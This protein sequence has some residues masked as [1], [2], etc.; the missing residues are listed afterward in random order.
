MKTLKKKD[1]GKQ[2]YK[3]VFDAVADHMVK[4]QGWEYCPKSEWK[5][6]VRDVKSVKAKKSVKR[7]TRKK[8]K[9]KK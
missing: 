7:R 9:D 3:Q 5:E 2:E 8:V 4:N 6:K 1:K